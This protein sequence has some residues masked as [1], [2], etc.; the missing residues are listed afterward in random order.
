MTDKAVLGRVELRRKQHGELL[1][2]LRTRVSEMPNSCVGILYTNS[3]SD[4][5]L[6]P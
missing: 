4:R 1:A 6:T 2:D 5:A 3:L